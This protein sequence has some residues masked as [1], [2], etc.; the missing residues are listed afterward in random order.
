[1]PDRVDGHDVLADDCHR[2]LD[3]SP[4]RPAADCK[5]QETQARYGRTHQDWC[6]AVGRASNRSISTPLL[7]FGGDKMLVCEINMMELRSVIPNRVMNPTTGPSD[8]TPPLLRGFF[9]DPAR[10]SGYHLAR[11]EA[12]GLCDHPIMH[13]TDG[14]RTTVR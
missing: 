11:G 8:S 4:G 14:N 2:T 1:M 7:S 13:T 10:D 6:K 3:L 5:R 9:G 12:S